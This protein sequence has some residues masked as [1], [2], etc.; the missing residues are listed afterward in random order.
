MAVTLVT[1]TSA[2]RS[3]ST[4]ANLGTALLLAVM[5]AAAAGQSNSVERGAYLAAAAGCDQCHTDREH[6]GRP[7]AGG[8][9]IETRFGTIVTPNITPD[10]RTG[11]GGWSVADFTR[12]MRWGV[13]PDASHYLPAFPFPYYSR[14][15]LR[16]LADLKAF[17]DSVPAV[18][19]VN[20]AGATALFAAA[21]AA[22]AVLASAFP[23]PWRPDPAKDAMWNRGAYLVATVGRC[24]D[25]H[26][27]RNWLGALDPDGAMAGTAAGPGGRKVPNITSDPEAGIGAW[28]LDDI[29]TL[30]KDGETPDFNFV[31]GP[32]GEIVRNTSRLDDADRQAIAVYLKSLPPIRSPKKD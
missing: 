14:L 7:Y 9:A 12:A 25:C 1:K 32:M 16:D 8:R 24:G 2:K 22:V 6:G 28:S 29:E 13:A 4:R 3:S 30:L 26:T 5:S 17:L 19:Q 21:R 20:R 18:S 11:I 10:I 31:G 23:G 27:P 15:T